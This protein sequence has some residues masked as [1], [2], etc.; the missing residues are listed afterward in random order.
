MIILWTM[1]IFQGPICRG[2]GG[3]FNAPNN[4]FDPPSLRRFELLGGGVDSN[5]S[6]SVTC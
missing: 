6:V 3:R 5:P 2:G 1:N 4:F